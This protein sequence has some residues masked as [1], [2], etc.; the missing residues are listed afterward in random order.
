MTV[1]SGMS[2]A[3]QDATQLGRAVGESWRPERTGASVWM[4]GDVR[5]AKDNIPLGLIR[6]QICAAPGAQ[7]MDAAGSRVK[8]M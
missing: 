1:A 8:S 7:K 2:G 4:D 5:A 6:G 3:S